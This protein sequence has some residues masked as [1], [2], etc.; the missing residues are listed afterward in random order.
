MSSFANRAIDFNKE[1]IAPKRLP[2]NFRV[3]NPFADNP[4]TVE[5][6]EQFYHKFYTDNNERRFIVGINP[7][8]LGAGTTGVP[9]TDTKR[10]LSHC[11]IE[12]KSARTHEIS[13]V[14]VY[15]MIDAY[16]GAEKFYKDF[17]INS[18]FPLAIVRQ[19]KTGDWINANYYDDRELFAALKEYMIETLRKLIKIGLDSSEVF[20]WGKKNADF[21]A[22]LDREDK[23]FDKLTVLEHPR[24]IQ[25]YKLR[26]RQFY[27]DKYLSAFYGQD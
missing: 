21:I 27:I 3:L 16:G 22:R 20:V 14:F 1:L 24:Y 17:Y 9:F 8:R 19:S 15:D 12:M 10:L 13:S 26:E 4:E 11:D 23:L 6:M 7:G 5:V 18:P 25:Q 2:N